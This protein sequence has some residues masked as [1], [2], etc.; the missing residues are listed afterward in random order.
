MTTWTWYQHAEDPAWSGTWLDSDGDVIDFTGDTFELKLVTMN[1][2]TTVLTKTTGITGAATAP[3]VIAQWGAGELDV[4]PGTYKIIVTAT[5][6]GRQRSPFGG[7]SPDIAKIVA[8]PPA[9]IP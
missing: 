1:G 6:S 3:N 8:T 7:D 5:E 9:V 4:T 2:A